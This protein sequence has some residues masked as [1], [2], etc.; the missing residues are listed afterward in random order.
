VWAA[1]ALP[2]WSACASETGEAHH[3]LPLESQ[4]LFDLCGIPIT[5]SMIECI[6]AGALIV[7]VAQLAT[8]KMTFV[9]GRLQNFVEW[10]VESLY[11]F[12]E[13]FLGPH[14]VKRTFWVLAT[15]FI[16]ILMTNWVGLLPGGGSIGWGVQ[17]PH[18]FK[19]TEPLMRGANA[20][21][22]MTLGFALFFTVM[23]FVW[24]LQEQGPVGMIKHLFAPKGGMKGW[25]LGLMTLLFFFVGLVEVFQVLL[26]R[27]LAFTFRLYGNIYAGENLMETLLMFKHGGWLVAVLGYFLE[28]LVGLIQATVFM[29]LAAA[30][31][32]LM[33][34]HEESGESTGDGAHP[35][36]H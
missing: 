6:A 9:P 22:N 10:L 28:I 27:P 29:L 15:L 33:C 25:M 35:A 21:V 34:Q 24:S 32:L 5:N 20:D 11:E 3:G 18:G 17:T 1:T 23:W 7:L 30:F 12:L 2:A 8:R 14:L 31:T 26:V 13:G 36:Q 19:V 16:F 4:R